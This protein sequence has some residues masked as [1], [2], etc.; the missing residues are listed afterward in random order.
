MVSTS[1]RQ[2]PKSP[3][4]LLRS[5]ILPMTHRIR[6]P[7][8]LGIMGSVAFC[9]AAHMGNWAVNQNVLPS[10]SSLST[11]IRPCIISTKRREI[12]KPRPVPPCF[13]VVDPSACVNAWNKRSCTSDAKPIPV[14]ATAKRKLWVRASPS[15]RATCTTTSPPSVN[16]MALPTRLV[17]ICRNRPGSPSTQVGTAACT[18]LTSSMPLVAAGSARISNTSSMA[19][20]SSKLMISSSIL[21]ASILEKSKISL[22]IDNSARPERRMV[23]A[24]SR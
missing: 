14:S 10:P 17:K 2:E 22:M 13:R 5:D 1:I 19:R 9:G 24:K 4:R 8:R 23:S 21:P 16:L 3:S 12:A 18:K 15:A 6:V 20:R 7:Y 11:P